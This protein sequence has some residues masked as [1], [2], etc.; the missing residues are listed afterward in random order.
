MDRCFRGAPRIALCLLLFAGCTDGD[1]ES[2]GTETG[3]A[4]A[5]EASTSS[6]STDAASGGADASSSAGMTGTSTPTDTGDTD[7]SGSS[8]TT[9]GSDGPSFA[10]DVFPILDAHCSCHK[11][12]AGMLRLNADKA[13]ANLVGQPSGLAPLLMIVEPGSAIDSYLWHK[14][15]DTQ[16]E[17]GGLGQR[18]PSGGLLEQEK[19]EQ[20]AAWIDAGARP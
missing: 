18:M 17:V 9:G 20:I 16:L 13:Y 5:A 14:L 6:G 7:S 10:V 11:D 8:G 4:T 2:G 12:G 1:T 19:R 3:T 15:N